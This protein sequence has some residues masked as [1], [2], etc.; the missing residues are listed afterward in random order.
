MKKTW[1]K[2]MKT[3]LIPNS[4]E[5]IKNDKILTIV[6]RQ[7]QEEDLEEDDLDEDQEED[8]EEEDQEEE[9]QDGQE[10]ED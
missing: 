5:V 2:M 7:R 8:Q 6:T 9:D 4:N 3:A 1:M 10:Y